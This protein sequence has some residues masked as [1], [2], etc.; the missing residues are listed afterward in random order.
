[1]DDVMIEIGNAQA[2]V[3]LVRDHLD[4]KEGDG[5]EAKDIRGLMLT[6]DSA[7]QRLRKAHDGIEMANRG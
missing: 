4:M 2:L 5:V 6:L 1:M 3:L 7:A